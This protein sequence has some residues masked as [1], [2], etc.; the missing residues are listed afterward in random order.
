MAKYLV[1]VDYSF[2][3]NDIQYSNSDE[4][5]VV[6]SDFKP[7]NPVDIH[8]AL[9]KINNIPWFEWGKV[10]INYI[11]I[12]SVTNIDIINL[13]DEEQ[14][15]TTELDGEYEVRV[16]WSFNKD[17]RKLPI[18]E[19]YDYASDD[20]NVCSLSNSISVLT[21]YPYAIYRLALVSTNSTHIEEIPTGSYLKLYTGII[22]NNISDNKTII[23]RKYIQEF[24]NFLAD[25]GY[26][27][28]QESTKNL[29]D[30]TDEFEKLP[31]Y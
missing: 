8:K 21:K 22:T 12:N 3:Y 17:N 26:L 2:K 18:D 10:D 25:K 19:F 27:K 1:N 20:G 16:A 15:I 13:D 14:T 7:T 31:E 6:E 23:P 28:L 5:I 11:D 29:D 4:N 24:L 9:A 30:L